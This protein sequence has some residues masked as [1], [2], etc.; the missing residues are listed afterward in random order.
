MV[1]KIIIIILNII[2]LSIIW[3]SK[4]RWFEIIESEYQRARI[5][6]S[7]DSIFEIGK[8]ILWTIHIDEKRNMGEILELEIKAP[9]IGKPEEL[10][11]QLQIE[12]YI[13]FKDGNKLQRKFVPSKFG[14][15]LSKE[16]IGENRSGFTQEFIDP[17]IVNSQSTPI[18]RMGET[19][20]Y[21]VGNFVNLF[22]EPLTIE[23]K[24]ITASKELIGKPFHMTVNGKYDK[25]ILGHIWKIHLFK[26]IVFFV[27][28]FCLLLINKLYLSR[29]KNK[30]SGF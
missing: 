2:L 4:D 22:W 7:K 9:T 5:I 17:N 26:Y 12:G 11:F 6:I 27:S 30:T 25:A 23:I 20:I 3:L 16:K 21:N 24:I 13:K 19:D 28:L 8:E 15:N 1:R 18:A 10:N 14:Q 29:Q